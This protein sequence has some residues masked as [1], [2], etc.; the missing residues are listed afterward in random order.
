M[1][2]KSGLL[3]GASDS[4]VLLLLEHIMVLLHQLFLLLDEEVLILRCLFLESSTLG[5]HLLCLFLLLLEELDLH[6][7]DPAL[8]LEAGQLCP[9]LQL[10]LFLLELS[11]LQLQLL[12][13]PLRPRLLL[14]LP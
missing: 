2:L 13:K 3:L 8:L 4:L 12:L 11:L 9:V 14:L 6:R 7:V 10:H 5:C 1:P